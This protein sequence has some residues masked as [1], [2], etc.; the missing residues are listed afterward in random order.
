MADRG[1]V[2]R[3]YGILVRQTADRFEQQLAEPLLALGLRLRNESH[4]LGRTTLQDLLVED[5]TSTSVAL[6]RLGATR[7]NPS[8]WRIASRAVQMLR[9][10]DPDDTDTCYRAEE[11]LTNFLKQLRSTMS[12]TVPSPESAQA[13]AIQVTSFLGNEALAP[14][15]PE[16]SVGQRLEIAIEAFQ[17]H[18]S[19]SGQDGEENWTACIDRLKDLSQIPLM[20]VHK[21]KGLGIRHYDFCRTG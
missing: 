13:V 21:S 7:R 4:A 3:D 20:T 16:S 18:L 11:E 8:A 17:L 12:K 2:P 15:C 6:L 10:A 14:S 19:S 9:A 1:T 5:Y